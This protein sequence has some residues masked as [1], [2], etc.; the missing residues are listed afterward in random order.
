MPSKEGYSLIHMSEQVYREPNYLIETEA[1]IG[2][3]A[4]EQP[5]LESTLK[6]DGV[7][8]LP[9][10][11]AESRET[12]YHGALR[13]LANARRLERHNA[14]I[15]PQQI[16]PE[17]S[18]KWNSTWVNSLTRKKIGEIA[19][20]ARE[21]VSTISAQLQA[22]QK[23]E[24]ITL[25]HKEIYDGL[26]AHQRPY[27]NGIAEFMKQSPV[28]HEITNSKGVKGNYVIH[29]ATIEA[30]TGAG[31]TAL[32]GR[33]AVA[34][35]IGETFIDE[36]TGEERTRRMLVVVPSRALVRQFTGKVGD[37]TFRR[38]AGDL[39]V[40]GYYSAEKTTDTD[41]VVMTIEKFVDD[42][43][44]SSLDGNKFD[45]LA[46]DEAHHLMAPQFLDTLLAEWTK[47]VIGFTATPERD[48]LRDLR[49]I[50]PTTIKHADTLSYILEGV[51]NGAQ[52]FLMRVDPDY[53]PGMLEDHES[54]VANNKQLKEIKQQAINQAVV[55]FVRPLLETGR[56]GIIF[57]NPGDQSK[58]ARNMA[59]I[60]SSIQ[61]EDGRSVKASCLMAL[62][63]PAD[64]RPAH[65]VIKD[66]DE[67]KIDVLTTVDMAKEGLNAEIDFVIIA[68]TIRSK[69][70]L[71]QCL[72][73]GTRLSDKFP[74]TVYAQFVVPSLE[75]NLPSIPL[76]EIFGLDIVEQGEKVGPELANKRRS[77]IE[78][79]EE[80]ALVNRFLS[81]TQNLLTKVE[82]KIASEVHLSYK[83]DEFIPPDFVSIQTIFESVED[84]SLK[85]SDIQ[86][87]LDRAGY[88]WRGTIEQR[89][90]KN[91]LHRHYEPNAAS[92]F[93]EDNL[94]PLANQSSHTFNMLVKHLGMGET[95]L[96]RIVAEMLEE[97]DIRPV[98]RLNDR[99]RVWDYYDEAALEWIEQRISEMPTI[100]PGDVT[101]ATIAA[102]LDEHM[103]AARNRVV[104][105]G[106]H[107]TYKRNPNH[108]TYMWVYSK[109]EYAE[110]MQQLDTIPVAVEN[111]VSLPQIAIRAGITQP[112]AH[113]LISDEERAL[114]YLRRTETKSGQLQTIFHLPSEVAEQVITRAKQEQA[115]LSPD[116]I[117]VAGI[118]K[119]IKANKRNMPY[120]FRGQEIKIKLQYTRNWSY[121]TWKLAQ[122]MIE[123]YGYESDTPIQIDF[124][125]LPQGPTDTD[126]GRITYARAVQLHFMT[127]RELGNPDG[128]IDI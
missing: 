54:I 31:K 6:Y 108:G 105:I 15:E 51:L 21:E 36:K 62:H 63:S 13:I 35:G 84:R 126:P 50:L 48:E 78:K 60:I 120:A 75:S 1:L 27:M 71:Q 26:R 65:H 66:Y 47:P 81:S 43:R 119:I 103:T 118:L 18:A 52:L 125:R 68:Q 95:P 41:V 14:D 89:D 29:G 44:N 37:D 122:Q 17:Q 20:G 90:G 16:T 87:R 64:E 100:Q 79:D 112:K 92:Y 28:L 123:K 25:H 4:F 34:A 32:I 56:R 40:G 127:A 104:A 45:L 23:S 7:A 83:K 19:D 98:P 24:L 106:F 124:D 76:H 46:I 114:G 12:L 111:D 99:G 22:Q 49:N 82:G 61:L 11:F 94:P 73:R 55:D 86:R 85:I 116:Y 80:D 57:C 97:T 69:L 42:V 53:D 33:T 96:R 88:T 39:T 74:H 93:T 115:P 113:K 70:V 67:G 8:A 91:Y 59:D 2:R 110:I 5:E 109:E 3:P 58:H 107:P 9:E 38:F 10:G 121:V 128:I 30:P 117:L 72:G 101:I 102:E 77:R